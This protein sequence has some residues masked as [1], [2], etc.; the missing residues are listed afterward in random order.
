ME[1]KRREALEQKAALK[2]YSALKSDYSL[3]QSRNEDILKLLDKQQEE[4]KRLGE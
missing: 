3:L 1:Q 4:N 2:N